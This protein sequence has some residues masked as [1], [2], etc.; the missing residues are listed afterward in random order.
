MEK[1]SVRFLKAFY[2][3]IEKT[4][5]PIHFR[6]NEKNTVDLE[7]RHSVIVQ[8]MFDSSFYETTGTFFFSAFSWDEREKKMDDARRRPTTRHA[9]CGKTPLLLFLPPTLSVGR[10]VISRPSA[11]SGT[12]VSSK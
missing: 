6:S 8:C 7:A 5:T 1:S 4:M 12:E 10:S 9:A 3:E 2:G 11:L